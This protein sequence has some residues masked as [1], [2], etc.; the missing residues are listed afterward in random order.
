MKP[1]AVLVIQVKGRLGNQMLAYALL[2][3]VR[4][5][6]KLGGMRPFLEEV[7][8]RRLKHIFPA[9]NQARSTLVCTVLY[10]TKKKTY[11]NGAL[12]VDS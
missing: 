6:S 11:L 2:L 8:L 7:I 12:I 4:R 10:P 9:A 1:V 5:A 3:G